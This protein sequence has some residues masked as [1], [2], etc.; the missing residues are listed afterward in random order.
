MAYE[1]VQQYAAEIDA[2]SELCVKNDQID[3]ELYKKYDVKR[4][5]RDISGRGVLA[6]LT[7][8]GEIK[9]YDI[10]DGRMIPARGELFYRGHEINDIVRGFIRE[11]R[12]GFDE[13]SY[14]LL[15]GDLPSIEELNKFRQMMR[16]ITTLPK[17]FVRDIIMKAPTQDVMN[18]LAR[19]VLT[20]YAYDPHPDDTSVPNVLRQC[21]ELIA[22]FPMISV[23]GYQAYQYYQFG[24]NFF[25][26][27]PIPEY[28]VAE[29]ILHMLREDSKF[30]PLEARILDLAGPPHGAWRR[31]QF[32]VH[33]A[34][35][36]FIRD[37]HVFFRSRLPGF[38]EGPQTRRREHQGHENVPGPEGARGRLGR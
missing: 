35:R 10:V 8:I 28:G 3:P 19:S 21:L 25:I 4:G 26:H 1:R 22:V 7:E 27:G 31:Q 30:T 36:Q 37:R 15:F 38:A 5:L 24:N 11:N 9:A 33:D 6:G 17:H 13:V 32:H 16:D 2:L 18:T 14:L 20:L 23:Y 34:R 12:Y 29:N